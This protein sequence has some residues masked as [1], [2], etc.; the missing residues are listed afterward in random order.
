MGVAKVR[1]RVVAR[2]QFSA[3]AMKFRAA[4]K[5]EMGV[6]DLA[7]LRPDVYPAG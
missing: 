1:K 3:A 5:S 6:G 2:T 7:H 4:I